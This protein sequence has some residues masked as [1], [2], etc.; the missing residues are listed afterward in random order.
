MLILMAGLPGSGKST[1]ARR[2]AE[3]LHGAV[4][5]KDT[6]RHAL[7]PPELVEYSSAQ[8][9]FVIE[10]LL[11]TAE[12]I[13]KRARSKIV[14]LDGRTFS[15]ASQRTHVIEF[16]EKQ[17]QEWRIV[18][19]VCADDMARARLA[20]VDSALFHPAAN[21]TPELY[22][23]VRRRWEPIAEPKLTVKTDAPVNFAALIERLQVA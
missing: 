13:W 3:H 16:A 14:I 20:K 9:D 15:R 23:E 2:L 1:V 22:N 12:Y 19:C 11:Q 10:L 8:D 18:E 7:F 4:L 5:S 6:L 17:H 21:R